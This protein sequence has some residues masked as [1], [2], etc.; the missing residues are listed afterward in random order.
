MARVKREADARTALQAEVF[1]DVDIGRGKATGQIQNEILGAY[2][3]HEYEP[4]TGFS[5]LSRFLAAGTARRGTRTIR[6][7]VE[8][9]KGLRAARVW[10][11][12]AS[13]NDLSRRP[14]GFTMK[15]I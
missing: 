15:R 5:R 12:D 9:V 7:A 13:S 1:E 14:T 10:L 6:L 3:A 4:P 2:A 8:A 11:A